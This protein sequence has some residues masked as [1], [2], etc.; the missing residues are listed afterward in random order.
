[1]ST[2]RRLTLSSLLISLSL[3]LSKIKFSLFFI[4]GGSV[5]LFSLVPLIILSS[6]FGCKWGTLCGFIFGFFHLVTTNLKFQGLNIFSIFI[7][8]FL[9]YIISYMVFGLFFYFK[10]KLKNSK[11][12]LYI[13]IIYIFLLKL[14]I[15]VISGIIVWGPVLKK[16]LYYGIIYSILYNLAYLV[17]EMLISLF[18]VYIIKKILPNI[19]L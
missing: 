9:D 6:K 12:C 19:F 17:P 14:M 2:L 7:S 4:F 5:T 15:H 18:G 10:S 16:S 13:S 1:M 3:L 11:Y 8:I